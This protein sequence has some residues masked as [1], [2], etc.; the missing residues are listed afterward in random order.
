MSNTAT[1]NKIFYAIDIDMGTSET[2]TNVF[3]NNGH[4]RFTTDNYTPPVDAEYENGD[5]VTGT[6]YTDSLKLDGLDES[7]INIDITDKT[8]YA[9][10]N[11]WSFS[12]INRCANNT[13]FHK[14]IVSLSSSYLIGSAITMYVII[15]DIF[16]TRW[17]GI[18][19]DYALDEKYFKINCDDKFIKDYKL[20]PKITIGNVNYP[21]AESDSLGKVIPICLGNIKYAKPINISSRILKS[22]AV[23]YPLIRFKPVINTGTASLYNA[24]EDDQINVNTGMYGQFMGFSTLVE[25]DNDDPDDNWAS[26][27]HTL[28]AI[29]NNERCMVGITI[30]KDLPIS[31]FVGKYISL[32]KNQTLTD[33]EK[34]QFEFYRVKY[35]HSGNCAKLDLTNTQLVYLELEVLPKD[36]TDYNN[37]YGNITDEAIAD[38]NKITDEN[39]FVYVWDYT[40]EYKISENDITFVD[41]TTVDPLVVY[42]KGPLSCYKLISDFITNMAPMTLFQIDGSTIS[43]MKGVAEVYHIPKAASYFEY[44]TSDYGAGDVT[45][46]ETLG[47]TAGTEKVLNANL[48]WDDDNIYWQY[49]KN[50]S[51]K[52][53]PD[54]LYPN[55]TYNTQSMYFYNDVTGEGNDCDITAFN[56]TFNKSSFNPAR[57]S[58][59]LP[60]P[61]WNAHAYSRIGIDDPLQKQWVDGYGKRGLEKH[62]VEVYGLTNSDFNGTIK[63][64]IMGSIDYPV[65]RVR[66]YGVTNDHPQSSNQWGY[67]ANIGI[68]TVITNAIEMPDPLSVSTVTGMQPSA[69]YDNGELNNSSVGVYMFGHVR[70]TKSM[71][72]NYFKSYVGNDESQVLDRSYSVNSSNIVDSLWDT[73]DENGNINILMEMFYINGNDELP[74]VGGKTV[75]SIGLTG[76][77]EYEPNDLYFR[78]SGECSGQLFDVFDYILNAYNGI[79]WNGYNNLM[80][81]RAQYFVGRQVTEQ[82]NTVDYI[83]ELCQ[84]SWCIGF[85]DR[86]GVVTIKAIEDNSVTHTHSNNIILRD[87][88]KNFQLTPL[89]K[90]YNELTVKA[91][92]NAITG[93]YDKVF[94]VDNIED[95]AF[96]TAYDK[97]PSGEIELSVST[98]STPTYMDQEFFT[99]PYITL[100]EYVG[101][102]LIVG[103]RI[104]VYWETAKLYVKGTGV[105]EEELV[106]DGASNYFEGTVSTITVQS[107]PSISTV[108]LVDVVDYPYYNEGLTNSYYVIVRNELSLVKKIDPDVT[109]G[110]KWKSY[111]QGIDSYSDAKEI[112]DT[113]KQGY[114]ETK[115]I[116]QYPTSQSNLSWLVDMDAFLDEEYYTDLGQGYYRWFR[117]AITWLTRQKYKITYSIPLTSDTV[118]INLGDDVN[119]HDDILIGLDP[120]SLTDAYLTGKVVGVTVVPREYKIDIDLMAEIQY[121]NK[122]ELDQSDDIWERN[123]NNIDIIEDANNTDDIIET[124]I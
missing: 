112:W 48:V 50:Y 92:Y 102:S 59:V 122:S 38:I 10:L 99:T 45:N 21:Y 46:I 105:L 55:L 70:P 61:I 113:C 75:H 93:N 28:Y 47:S 116:N 114:N 91:D 111:V 39:V 41:N 15:D 54:M 101:D 14:A 11:A 62:R 18:V 43:I 80:T 19:S 107:N 110:Y 37:F 117:K 97:Q 5:L 67:L 17:S 73:F 86:E 83:D 58:Y 16:Y 123:I 31:N 109:M 22:K 85:T 30:S 124:G 2:D 66:A 119:F 96:P 84:Q 44:K 7:S 115:T 13:P 24:M 121:F 3:L 23:S 104:R 1:T 88:I 12:I 76:Y 87:S 100:T 4:I 8:G 68:P 106:S 72:F 57:Y 64:S 29:V 74:L 120:T 35:A 36:I 33:D 81:Y 42:Q 49:A 69:L 118:K 32:S 26:Q 103:D 60:T 9:T 108:L 27:P 65:H 34:A 94:S 63:T 6:W 52:L 51:S 20:F 25:P 95:A 78:V 53:N 90:V 98:T 79:T 82:K 71:T 56:M 40:N 77:I 89:T